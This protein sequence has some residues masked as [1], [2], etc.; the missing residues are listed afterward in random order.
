[1][2]SSLTNYELCVF[3]TITN[4]EVSMRKVVIQFIIDKQVLPNRKFNFNFV[5][6]KNMK[7]AEKI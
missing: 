1:M 6:E 2:L 7:A 5:F 4:V 3:E